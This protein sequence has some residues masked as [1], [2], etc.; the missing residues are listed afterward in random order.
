MTG[1]S[2]D[3]PVFPLV[4]VSMSTAKALESLLR[5]L[6]RRPSNY[7]CFLVVFLV[8]NSL[9]NAPVGR[10]RLGCIF[11]FSYVLVDVGT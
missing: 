6:L 9:I 8:L 4:E 5:F 1:C 11:V 7:R 2:L 10:S 3:S